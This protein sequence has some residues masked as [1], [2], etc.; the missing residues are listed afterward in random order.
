MSVNPVI[1]AV[2]SL[3]ILSAAVCAGVL[4]FAFPAHSAAACTKVDVIRADLLSRGITQDA[5]YTLE[6]ARQVSD[7][8]KAMGLQ[9]PDDSEPTAMFF[10][11][12]DAVTFI[13]ASWRRIVSGTPK[14]SRQRCINGP[15]R[16]Q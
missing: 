13:S 15:S 1:R 11:E 7:Y 5:I 2:L 9:I 6:G 3:L 14:S 8:S 10:V 12:N 16:S 4:F